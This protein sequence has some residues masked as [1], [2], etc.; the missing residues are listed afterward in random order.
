[1]GLIGL[2]V[3]V[4]A[5]LNLIGPTAPNDVAQ[6]H[7]QFYLHASN[8]DW[9]YLVVMPFYFYGLLRQVQRIDRLRQAA[10][11]GSGERI[12][13]ERDFPTGKDSIFFFPLIFRTRFERRSAIKFGSILGSLCALLFL[14]SMLLTFATVHDPGNIALILSVVS[15]VILLILLVFVLLL[16]LYR[17]RMEVTAEGIALH[18]MGRVQRIL[19]V[20]VRLFASHKRRIYEVSSSAVLLTWTYLQ[21]GNDSEPELPWDTYQQQMDALM[22]LIATKTGLP[23]YDLG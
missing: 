18:R 7:I 15:L 23:L 21:P 14:F 19:W 8:F 3:L 4:G 11:S 17:T 13:L 9:L 20:D 2:G 22:W 1:M 10:A 5:L 16:T 6:L 12:P